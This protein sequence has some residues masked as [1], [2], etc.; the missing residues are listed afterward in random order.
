MGRMEKGSSICRP[1]S[2]MPSRKKVMTMQEGMVSRWFHEVSTWSGVGLGL[3]LGVG[4]G[5]GVG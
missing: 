2:S 1:S 5:V 3:G 4:V